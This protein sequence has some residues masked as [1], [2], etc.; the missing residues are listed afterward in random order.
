MKSEP[1]FEH[2]IVL[3]KSS[4][5]SYC[6]KRGVNMPEYVFDIYLKHGCIAPNKNGLFSIYQIY[7]LKELQHSL[8]LNL[9]PEQL[10]DFNQNRW[11][12]VGR[13]IAEGKL[14]AIQRAVKINEKWEKQLNLVRKI[15]DYEKMLYTKF[16]E[17]YEKAFGT[18]DDDE[19]YNDAYYSEPFQKCL[20]EIKTIN[21]DPQD[22]LNTYYSFAHLADSVDPIKSLYLILP[23]IPYGLIKRFQGS[24]LFAYET[25]AV[26]KSLSNYLM[27]AGIEHMSIKKMTVGQDDVV[28]CSVCNKPVIKSAQRQTTCLDK[29][30]I[31]QHKILIKRLKRK[32]GFYST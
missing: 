25:R 13:M 23:S 17:E 20:K 14:K 9:S 24:A 3:S 1:V 8:S 7:P 30:C 21:I 28:F 18:Y 32:S 31:A 12:G 2:E 15:K 26:A 27:H 29:K 10:F 16:G 22:A 6:R 11:N 4:F 5:L 19:A